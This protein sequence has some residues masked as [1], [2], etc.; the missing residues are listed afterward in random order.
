MTVDILAE[1]AEFNLELE[2]DLAA[3]TDFDRDWAA[4]AAGRPVTDR[5][6]LEFKRD[7]LDWVNTIEKVFD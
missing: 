1:A 5:E 3:L 4:Q 7:Y 2:R 6:A